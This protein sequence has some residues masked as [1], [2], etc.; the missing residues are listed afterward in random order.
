MGQVYF[1]LRPPWTELNQ[2]RPYARKGVRFE[3]VY[4]KWGIPSRQ[5]SGAQN[6]LHST[7][8]QLNDN[9]CSLYLWKETQY[10]QTASVLK[11]TSGLLHR[12]KMS[13][14]LVNKRLE[15][16]PS[17]LPNLH[18]FCILYFIARLRTQRSTNGIQ[19]NFAKRWTVNRANNLS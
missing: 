17:F 16:G 9:F 13:W 7:T 10:A 8:W 3:N 6:Y 4:P 19:A 5:K 11:T 18:T 2:N 15:T 12:H 14:T 1:T